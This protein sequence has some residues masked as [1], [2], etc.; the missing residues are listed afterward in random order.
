M[1]EITESS[2]FTAW[3][4]MITARADMMYSDRRVRWTHQ[5]LM[6]KTRKE[7]TMP[8]TE[9]MYCPNCQPM[10]KKVLHW[11]IRTGEWI[12]YRCCK[13]GNEQTYKAS[14]KP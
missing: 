1:V 9:M 4:G 6:E 13:C 3:V 11:V 7:T 2:L 12:T 14:A 8:K 5:R 10:S